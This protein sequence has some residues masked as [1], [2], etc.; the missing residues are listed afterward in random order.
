MFVSDLQT[1]QILAVSFDQSSRIVVAQNVRRVE[2][3]A[4][5]E[6]N[7]DVYFST[8]KTIQR[9]NV[10]TLDE[11][12]MPRKGTVILDLDKGDLVRGLAVNPCGSVLYFTNWR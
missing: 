10:K 6:V 4:Y 7:K 12:S 5:D 2:G 8:D 9:I 3:L 11:E 1:E